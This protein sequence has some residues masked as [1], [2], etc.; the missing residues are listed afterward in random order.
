M[1]EQLDDMDPHSFSR[2]LARLQDSLSATAN[3]SGDQRNSFAELL[4]DDV[5]DQLEQ[6]SSIG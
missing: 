3:P 2:Q 1:F 4:A 6:R 5:G